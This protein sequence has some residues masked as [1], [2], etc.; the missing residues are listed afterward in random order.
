VLQENALGMTAL[1]L[2]G[3][4]ACTDF[5][6]ADALPPGTAPG[7]V[8]TVFAADAGV[9]PAN[10]AG[11]STETGIDASAYDGGCMPLSLTET[12][13]TPELPADW[14]PLR[15]SSGAVDIDTTAVSPP[16]ALRAHGPLQPTGIGQALLRATRTGAFRGSLDLTYRVSLGAL[17]SDA[18]YD[19]GCSLELRRADSAGIRARISAS[20]GITGELT[21][22]AANVDLRANGSSQVLPPAPPPMVLTDQVSTAFWY[23][24][25]IHAALDGGNVQFDIE[26]TTP[27]EPATVRGM[28][29]PFASVDSVVLSCGVD[30]AF[31]NPSGAGTTYDVRI[32]DIVLS[33]CR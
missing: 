21:G 30:D 24:V 3:A 9:P 15:Q 7:A 28:A 11:N 1:V 13:P 33:A 6:S 19:L 23:Q 32:D 8:A 5:T 10:D 16:F 31:S 29:I 26:T 25:H 2:L 20:W 17:L 22:V 27:T 14:A 4:G 18:R 12:F